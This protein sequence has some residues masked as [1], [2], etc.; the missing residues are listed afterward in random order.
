MPVNLCIGFWLINILSPKANTMFTVKKFLRPIKGRFILALLLI[1]GSL[2]VFAADTDDSDFKIKAK[3]V[4]KNVTALVRLLCYQGN[5]VI[6]V[7]NSK[8]SD[9]VVVDRSS[10]KKNEVQ[11]Y[12]YVFT[13]RLGKDYSGIF[14]S[15]KIGGYNII[16]YSSKGQAPVLT[17]AG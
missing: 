4:G 5:S 14:R 13:S 11:E 15:V 8:G 9:M 6:V 10:C 1:L 7:S 2:S 12:S 16:I 3:P 17:L